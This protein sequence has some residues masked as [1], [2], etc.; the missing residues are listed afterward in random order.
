METEGVGS[1][2]VKG[3]AITFLGIMGLTVLGGFK[4]STEPTAYSTMTWG[5]SMELVLAGI[6]VI[7]VLTSIIYYFARE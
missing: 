3:L 5:N 6:V 4:L 7:G 1:G 2:I